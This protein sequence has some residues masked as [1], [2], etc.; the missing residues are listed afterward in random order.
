MKKN[1]KSSIEHGI[2]GIFNV[3]IPIFVVNLTGGFLLALKAAFFQSIFT[4]FMVTINTSIFQFLHH[5]KFKYFAIIVPALL[6][7][8]LSFLLHYY[9][10]S[11]EPLFS[12][13]LVFIMAIWY[14]SVLTFFSKKHGT[15]SVLELGKIFFTFIPNLFFRKEKSKK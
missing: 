7:T 12:A 11:P 4:F 15:V 8:S 2:F 3:G 1:L 9:T 14:F 6:T 5:K 10:N 13:I